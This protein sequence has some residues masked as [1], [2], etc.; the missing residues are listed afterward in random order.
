MSLAVQQIGNNHRSRR[1]TYWLLGPLSHAISGRDRNLGMQLRRAAA[2][3]L[4]NIAEAQGSDAGNAR[5]RLHSASGSTLEV[6]AALHL[7]SAW[8][9]VRAADCQRAEAVLDRVSA[10]LYRLLHRKTQALG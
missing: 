1:W 8:G 3:M 4:L 7:A 6:R 5:A 10:M 9:Y 2:S